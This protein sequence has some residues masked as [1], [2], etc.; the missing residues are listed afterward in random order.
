MYYS[1]KVAESYTNLSIGERTFRTALGLGMIFAVLAETGPLGYLSLIPLIAIYPLMTASIGWDPVYRWLTAGNKARK[2][3]S[4]AYLFSNPR[5]DGM[6]HEST[7]ER[8]E[9]MA[10][11]AGLVAIPFLGQGLLSWHVAFPLLAIYPLT[12]A[13]LGIDLIDYLASQLGQRKH[14]GKPPAPVVPL[15]RAS[16]KK[17]ASDTKKAA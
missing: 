3:A 15:S 17:L 10:V 13:A 11:G 8:I 14:A 16:R 1:F 9:R 2:M 4:S 7:A 6:I 12:S 5:G